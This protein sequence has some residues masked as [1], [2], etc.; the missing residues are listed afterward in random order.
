MPGPDIAR[1]YSSWWCQFSGLMISAYN[2]SWFD[3]MRAILAAWITK[4]ARSLL[5]SHGF[6]LVQVVDAAQTTFT[7]NSY[8]GSRLLVTDSQRSHH[9]TQDRPARGHRRQREV[10][11]AGTNAGIQLPPRPPKRGRRAQRPLS[12]LTTPS[13]MELASA[14]AS[15]SEKI[16]DA[17]VT[18]VKQ[19]FPALGSVVV[20]LKALIPRDREQVDRD[21][22]QP[23]IKYML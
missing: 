23:S 7:P 5:T 6:G 19:A 12:Q 17:G 18:A 20:D 2:N 13:G 1:L 15:P 22:S 16:S 21:P 14:A 10:Q 3:C 11:P 8:N 4:D 9:R